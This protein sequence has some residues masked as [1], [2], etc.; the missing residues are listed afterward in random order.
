MVKKKVKYKAL[1]EYV[2]HWKNSTCTLLFMSTLWNDLSMNVRVSEVIN[3]TT[4][5]AVSEVALKF[6]PLKCNPLVPALNT[7]RVDTAERT[8]V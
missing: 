4:Y 2:M 8:N 7:K 1:T 5:T 3:A 6:C